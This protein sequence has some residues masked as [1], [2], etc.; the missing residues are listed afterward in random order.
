[1]RHHLPWLAVPVEL[2]VKIDD[3]PADPSL[4][5]PG[6]GEAKI[7]ISVN[8]V[9]RREVSVPIGAETTITL[10]VEQ[11]GKMVVR[12]RVDAVDEE[13]TRQNNVD[14]VSITGI[15]DRLRVLLVSGAPHPGERVWRTI[16]K[17]DP[18]VEL[19]HFTILR[20]RTKVDVTPDHE[21]SLIPLPIRD[22]F[23]TRLR[24]FDLIVFDRYTRRGLLPVSFMTNIV[25][26]VEEGGAFMITAGPEYAGLQSLFPTPLQA[27]LPI[28]PSGS[29]L[30][31][32]FTPR[33][34]DLGARHP[35]TRTLAGPTIG[36]TKKRWGRWLRLIEA[37]ASR[38]MVLMDGWGS[39]AYPWVVNRIGKGRGRTD[40]I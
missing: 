28:E 16:L 27:I 33:L 1:M 32:G 21:L 39:A 10:P 26:W 34:T 24:D 35:I 38:G 23:E 7:H 17:S 8:G 6:G 14:A 37:K 13:L 29:L 18:G 11:A 22:L 20:S 36:D 31:G 12:L 30:L 4:A 40:T 19:V 2:R 3:M 25:R 15:R 9:D 5:A